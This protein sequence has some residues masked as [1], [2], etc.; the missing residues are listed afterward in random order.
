MK[1]LLFVYNPKAGR[2]RAKTILSDVLTVFA[3]EG[4]QITVRPTL[5]RGDATQVVADTA[6]GYDRVVCCGGDGT[7]NETVR[8]LL[9]LPPG[10]RPILGYIPAGTTNDF[11]RN[12]NLPR[13]TQQ[14]ALVACGGVPRAIDVGELLDRQ[15]LYIAAFGL[16]TDVSYS[17]P[18]ASKNLLGHLAYVL[19]GAGRLVNFPSYQVKVTTD[20]GLE[21]EG[22]FIYGMV[23][24]TVSIGGLVNLPRDLVCLD[25]GQFEALL[26]RTPK[27][28]KNWQSILTALTTQKLPEDG[29]VVGFTCTKAHFTSPKPLAW[30]VDGE[31]GGE[32]TDL[33]I[34]NRSQAL[35]IA[36]GN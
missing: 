6:A 8:G 31:F 2:Q 36:C 24:N 15:F 3:Q 30:T 21:V 9:T 13:S 29:S 33:T 20:Q 16:F 23:S 35:V 7:L 12:I 27:T 5:K 32:Y 34:S 26:I 28:A 18:Q 10:Q 14:L 22:D 19:E 4:Y 11:S 1:Q 25:D 17:T